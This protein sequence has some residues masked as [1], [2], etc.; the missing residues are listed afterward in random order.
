MLLLSEGHL[1]C[2]HI[3]FIVLERQANWNFL[4]VQNEQSRQHS[5]H[6]SADEN[7]FKNEI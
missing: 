5:L 7:R 4:Y 6:F 1:L 2:R 3:D